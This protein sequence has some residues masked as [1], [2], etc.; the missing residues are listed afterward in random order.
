MDEQAFWIAKQEAERQR[1][2]QEAAAERVAETSRVSDPP[3]ESAQERWE[4][5][6]LEQ[7]DRERQER[8]ARARRQAAI[9]EAHKAAPID[10]NARIGTAIANERDSLM[11]LLEELVAQLEDRALQRLDDHL[12][13]VLVQVAELKVANARLREALIERGNSVG[14]SAGIS[15]ALN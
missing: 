10:W 7:A 5:E 14:G 6:G 4:R 13:P 1:A 15:S 11:A 12:R 2:E 8:R 9:V 3:I